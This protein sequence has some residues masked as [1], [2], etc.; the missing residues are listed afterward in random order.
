MS[1]VYFPTGGGAARRCPRAGE[2]DVLSQRGPGPTEDVSEGSQRAGQRTLHWLTKAPRKAD[3]AGQEKSRGSGRH[4]D[5]QCDK[6]PDVIR[7]VGL[8]VSEPEKG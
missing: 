6:L 8:E 2:G 1:S 4:P 5:S 3:V 7:P